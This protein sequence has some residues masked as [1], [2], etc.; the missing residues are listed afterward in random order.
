MK[1][2]HDILT[3]VLKE[4]TKPDVE[5]KDDIDKRVG[6]MKAKEG[7]RAFP[8][9]NTTMPKTKRKCINTDCRVS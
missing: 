1:M 6:E 7:M 2:I 5:W 4:H 3:K 9:G 8:V